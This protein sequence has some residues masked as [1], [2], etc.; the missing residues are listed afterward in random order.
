MERIIQI[1]LRKRKPG[2]RL[3]PVVEADGRR[4]N[5][6]KQATRINRGDEALMSW[7]LRTAWFYT[8]LFAVGFGVFCELLM[9][10]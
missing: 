4:R 7:F 8:H 3:F 10:L 9:L 2:P 1:L 5:G 6:K